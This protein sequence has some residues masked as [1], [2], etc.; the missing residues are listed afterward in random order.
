[1][2]QSPRVDVGLDRTVL[3][4]LVYDLKSTCVVFPILNADRVAFLIMNSSLRLLHTNS[5]EETETG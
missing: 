2:F 1:M 4:A 3:E 5:L